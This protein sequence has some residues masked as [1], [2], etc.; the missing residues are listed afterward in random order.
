[1]NED[2]KKE[3]GKVSEQG[4]SEGTGKTKGLG[5]KQAA[6]GLVSLCVIV[7][8]VV[9]GIL[10]MTGK[11]QTLKGYAKEEDVNQKI[12]DE[13][14][15]ASFDFLWANTNRDVNS[16]GFGLV[17]DRQTNANMASIASV[18]F[19]LTGYGIGVDNGWISKEEGQRRALGTLQTMWKDAEQEHG[20]FYHFLDINTGK[21][22]EKVE[23]S[24][25][26]TAIA[27]NGALFAGEY[28][29]GEVKTLA[30][31][32]Y[33]RIDWEWYR[34]PKTNKFYMEYLPEE[35]KHTGTWGVYAEQFMTYFLGS[36]SPTHPVPADM[37]Y[38][39]D[40]ESTTWAGMPP[41]ISS[42]ANSIFT[43]QFSQAYFDLQ[44]L[45]DNEGQDWYHNSV[46]ATLASRQYSIDTREIFK[47]FGPNAWGLTA[48][49][50]PFGYSGQY[51]ANP[52]NPV[53]GTIPPCG[54]G[55]SAPYAPS[56]VSK[57]FENYKN[58]DGLWDKKYGFKDAYN[59]EG[60]GTIVIDDIL[61]LDKG[62]TMV[63]IENQKSRL[64][65]DM[66]DQNEY[67]KK[68]KKLAGF[69]EADTR[70]IEDGEEISNSRGLK[71][72]GVRAKE[73]ENK[74]G[75]KGF[76]LK[77]DN[78]GD[79]CDVKMDLR[80]M[81]LTEDTAD[82]LSFEA[83][84]SA[85]ISATI[86][87]KRNKELGT[88]K[89]VKI[90]S[91]NKAETVS[92]DISEFKKEAKNFKKVVFH[93]KPEKDKLFLDELRF[94][95]NKDMVRNVTISERPYVGGELTVFFDYLKQD[96]EKGTDLF[97]YQ[98]MKADKMNDEFKP[99]K[100]AA[101]PVYTP[102][103]KDVNKYLQVKVTPVDKDGKKIGQSSM[104]SAVSKVSAEMPLVSEDIKETIL[105]NKGR[106][107]DVISGDTFSV[108]KYWV[109]GGEEVYEIGDKGKK[110][111]TKFE[112]KGT[113][114]PYM[115]RNI[116][117]K[118][119]S[120]FKKLA[121]SV[122]GD[123]KILIKLE[124][125]GAKP[126]GEV[127]IDTKNGKGYYEWDM[128]KHK[129]QLK[130]VANILIFAL[131][132]EKTGKGEFTFD[133]MEFS[134]KKATKNVIYS[135][136]PV[137]EPVNHY[138]GVS[139]EFDFNRYWLDGGDQVYNINE[140]GGET[141]IRYEKN[142]PEW[143]F[144]KSNV[145]GRLSSFRKIVL[146][147]SGG[148]GA[149]ILF[150]TEAPSG[151]AESGMLKLTGGRDVIEIN[152]DT[153]SASQKN[154]L[155]KVLLFMDP[156]EKSGAGNVTIHRAYFS[157]EAYTGGTYA[158]YVH[159]Y[160][161]S[162]DTLSINN[163]WYDNGDGV[164]QIS[165]GQVT[166]VDY[167]KRSK[168]EYSFMESLVDGRLS[169]FSYLN[170]EV[171]GK[172]DEQILFKMEGSGCAQ[173]YMHTFDGEKN[174]ISIP[175]D[176]TQNLDTMSH[177]MAFIGPGKTSGS[178]SFLLEKAY[179]SKKLPANAPRPVIHRY[180]GDKQDFH[181]TSGWAD[182]G[183]RVYKISQSGRTANVEYE[184]EKGNEWSSFSADVSGRFSDFKYLYVRA[185]G[186]KGKE[187]L[188]KLE[189]AG[190]AKEEKLT[191]N[192]KEQIIAIPLN[193]NSHLR[194]LKKIWM[195]ASPGRIQSGSLKLYDVYFSNSLPGRELVN[196]YSGN[197]KEFHFNRLW[198]DGGDGVHRITEKSGYV[199]VDVKK[200][201]GQ[202]YAL[203]YTPV[204]GR[205]TDFNRIYMEV[206]GEKGKQALFK[207]EQGR[208]VKEQWITFDGTR[209]FVEIELDPK[210]K[211]LNKIE[212]IMLFGA[213]GKIQ[214]T[215]FNIYDIYFANK[216]PDPV[217]TYSGNRK[218]FHA[219]KNWRS[220]DPGVYSFSKS[221]STVNVKSAKKKGNDWAFFYTPVSG[222]L[223]DFFYLNVKVKGRSGE[224]LLVKTENPD[225]PSQFK[226]TWFGLDGTEQ[227]FQ[228]PM[229]GEGY[230]NR[231]NKVML[232]TTPGTV[233][234]TTLSIR[235]VVFT[236]KK[237]V[238]PVNIYPGDDQDFHCN[239][240]YKSNDPGVYS[241]SESGSTVNVTSAKK[242]GNEWAFFYTPVEG[243]LS[244][245]SY[246][247]VLVKGRSGEQF[248]VKIEDQNDPSKF[249]ETWFSLDGS[250]QTL[251]IPIDQE[252]YRDQINKVMFFTTPGT[253][254]NATLAMKDVFFTNVKLAPPTNSYPGDNQ[255]FHCNDHYQ[256]NDPGVYGFTATDNGV[257]VTADKKAGNEW[258]FFYAPVEGRLSD[259][260]YLNIKVTG[261]SGE[262]LLA[263]VEDSSDPGQNKETYLNLDGSG[264]TFQI[265]LDGVSF[266]DR[267]SRVMFF[268]A[269]GQAIG[270]ELTLNDVYFTNTKESPAV[271]NYPGNNVDFSVMDG[272]HDS[273][274]G[275]YEISRSGSDV[276]IQADKH[277]EWST[278]KALVSGNLSDFAYL[279]VEVSGDTGKEIMV[280]LDGGTGAEVLEYKIVL[281]AD[282]KMLTIPL[283]KD[284]QKRS[285][286]DNL[287]EIL[288][289]ADPGV[290]GSQVRTV[291]HRMYFTNTR[292][293]ENVYAGIGD[294][295]LLANKWSPD[296]VIYG[297]LAD[298]YLTGAF[299]CH[300][301]KSSDSGWPGMTYNSLPSL[302]D[303]RAVRLTYRV[304]NLVAA[305]S[306]A[307]VVLNISGQEGSASSPDNQ[308][309]TIE[310]TYTP[311]AAANLMVFG[312]KAAKGDIEILDLRLIK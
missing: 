68:G 138:D 99:I 262:Q 305:D 124:E 44:N 25:I 118:D 134:V 38:E 182:S 295:P 272:W 120:K 45:V 292:P 250:E 80:P 17:K 159:R 185:K 277:S 78:A 32:I 142:G 202:E 170:F 43:Y 194:N 279:N 89:E 265:D 94:E 233:K 257:K 126:I 119:I 283:R 271:N 175:L 251:Q 168:T 177:V 112:K 52:E 198:K 186:D 2:K 224:Q 246:L 301:D 58:I 222:R 165:S 244:D 192:G 31:K 6:A 207:I 139:A 267:I 77:F 174:V 155:D 21:R 53:D 274:D 276:V 48:C 278:A 190:Y 216:L 311:G 312:G 287:K 114:Y 209:Q 294:F 20:F 235:D 141:K 289:F 71:G 56:L 158:K 275:D 72:K 187:L 3:K 37:I 302:G 82:A 306:I 268:A 147:V 245:F 92:L 296:G 162:G 266:R 200:K 154:A 219:N 41:Y 98:W 40:R 188:V 241:F 87:G 27:A 197:G 160:R 14:Q 176:K 232:F 239:K 214:N 298:D 227:T 103:K 217:N 39:I 255:N 50:G 79:T 243:R 23:V 236:N 208:Y 169:D 297:P 206:K 10:Y 253:L 144:A 133:K 65:W 183:D 131:P 172:E 110:L 97:A 91:E 125:I 225:N 135:K 199:H 140:G 30:D 299:K 9:S 106:V 173:E 49:D 181:I 12:L 35:G 105:K 84:G 156:A 61:S 5:K 42:P 113:E 75:L 180:K 282:R 66:M 260:R 15:K 212:K 249:K 86:Y 308:I 122:K 70:I 270:T 24:L 201:K 7:A 195:F 215:S 248:M 59:S 117:V 28:F 4:I 29:G 286:F 109:D 203:M 104:S 130:N 261:K 116:T 218:D 211:A 73:A 100:G 263:K 300:V 204:R 127:E 69:M 96:K 121:L 33:Q 128:T 26:D 291:L 88:T 151:N 11:P 55:G 290:N 93:I 189:T 132:G 161:G 293:G 67:V 164:Y 303:F 288:L 8:L 145:A 264:Q 205:F 95:T 150:K 196:V 171:R 304:T 36:A 123:A 167:A 221:G 226:E 13:E 247:N 152:L 234:N 111:I 57:A 83:E 220:N 22:Y 153:L 157:K 46:V 47:T 309:K 76:E 307:N 136:G 285:S 269:P 191:F 179:F 223:S 74:E 259:F 85:S 230:R 108:L 143:A 254:Q 228:I 107:P 229:A 252:S 149:G 34:N 193:N 166:Y 284:G 256:S 16:P 18:G 1:M 64:V 146:E 63:M 81:K 210:Q 115:I 163:K 54:A 240:F 273:G 148:K 60:D 178:G 90:S 242:Q 137:E 102:D 258:A 231:M 281:S 19:A 238:P 184:K 51:G 310:A 237:I 62:I 213:G 101:G 280:K 129:K